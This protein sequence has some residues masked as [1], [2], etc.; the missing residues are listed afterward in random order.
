MIFP[1]HPPLTS[2]KLISTREKVSRLLVALDIGLNWLD[3]TD[4]KE[5]EVGL[6]PPGS[7]TF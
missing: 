5:A 6:L 7:P 3:L 4:S 2:L 1:P